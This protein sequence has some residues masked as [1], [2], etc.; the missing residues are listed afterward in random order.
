VKTEGKKMGKM[1][2]RVHLK[3][4]WRHTIYCVVENKMMM[5]KHLQQGQT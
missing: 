1:A 5:S 3:L 2:K 4:C